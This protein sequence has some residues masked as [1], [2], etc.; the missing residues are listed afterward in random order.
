MTVHPRDQ[1]SDFGEAPLS[2]ITSGAIQ[3]G[4][5]ATLFSSRSIALRLRETPKSESLI[6]PVLVVRIFAALRSQCTT[7]HL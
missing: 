5:P 3:L 2:S 7:W 1:M 4:V 6:F